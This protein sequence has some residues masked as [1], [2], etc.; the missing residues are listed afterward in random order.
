MRTKSIALVIFGDEN[1]TRNALTE[2]NYKPLA[3]ALIEN[4]FSAESVLFHDT[5]LKQLEQKLPEFNAIMIWVDPIVQ[6]VDRRSL[7][8]LLIKVSQ[9][10]ILVSTHPD[11]IQKIGT[12][13]VLHSTREMEWGG[14]VELYSD[15]ENFERNFLHS[16]ESSADNQTFRILKKYRG[17]SGNGIYKIFIS[18]S[19]VC[20]IHASSPGNK[21]I[22]SKTEF[23]KEFQEYFETGGMLISQKW[24]NGIVNGMVRAY[25][26]GSKVT[27][28]GY[29][30][31]IALCQYTN[32]PD[33]P[34]RPI[35]KR[36]YFSEHCGIFQDL[37]NI[38]ETKWIPQLL[39]IHSISE[40]TMPLL[41]D[42]DLFINDVNT[43]ATEKKYTLCE[44]NVSGV[45]PFPP[46][47]INYIVNELK[48]RL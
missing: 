37:R 45:S 4:G 16:L 42:I 6:G 15:Y 33:S 41:W 29:Q 1:S 7:D 11:I 18:G 27:G 20:I 17:S 23:H 38:L 43:K 12:K 46:S 2:D 9:K 35:S 48:R 14:D 8:E 44:I 22:V 5:R 28:F 30:E 3:D 13:I 32:D 47:C 31:S 25:M 24:A 36:F 26:T 39:K 19:N 34:I 10:G 21:R 40:E